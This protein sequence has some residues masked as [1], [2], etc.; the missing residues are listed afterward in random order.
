VDAHESH[1]QERVVKYAVGSVFLLFGIFGVVGIWIAY[2][3]GL[4]KSNISHTT[5][6]ATG[7]SGG[8]GGRG[9]PPGLGGTIIGTVIASIFAGVGIFVIYLAGTLDVHSYFE[10]C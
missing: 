9:G 4:R 2:C 10:G 1:K 5:P 6:M 7:H 3:T 8:G